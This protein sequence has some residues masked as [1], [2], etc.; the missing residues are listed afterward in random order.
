MKKLITFAFALSLTCVSL[1]LA[2][3]SAWGRAEAQAHRWLLAVAFCLIALAVHLLPALLRGRSKLA[4][5]PVWALCFMVACWGHFSFLSATQN[6]AQESRAKV[7]MTTSATALA[8]AEQRKVIESELAQNRARSAATVAS[9]LARETDPAKRAALEIELEQGK[10]KNEL[11]AR[12]VE[13]QSNA[14]TGVTAGVIGAS[15]AAFTGLIFLAA[16]ALLEVL[17]MIFWREVFNPVK[18]PLEVTETAMEPLAERPTSEPEPFTEI[19]RLR[20]GLAA[21]NCRAT[22]ASIREFLGVGT[23]RAM[24]LRR[25]LISA[26]LAG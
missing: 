7:A 5:W 13:L 9:I 8:L 26:D 23:A 21:G 2:W 24:E 25:Q 15:N 14:V 12:L 18:M 1:A 19:A 4:I 17:G 20:A 10:R 3:A 22:V 16:A 6:E 11:L